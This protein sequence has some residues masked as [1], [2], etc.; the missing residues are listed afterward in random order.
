MRKTKQLFIACSLVTAG[1]LS[2]CASRTAYYRQ[3]DSLVSAKQYTGAAE[4]V[5]KSRKK[6][7]GSKNGLLYWLDRGMLLHYAGSY[8][9]SNAAFENAKQ[10]AE[11]QMV[12]SITAEASTF[13]VND[14]MRPYAGEDFERALIHAFSALNYLMLGRDDEALVEARQVDQYLISLENKYGHD[15]KYKE[16]AFVRY[17]MG[18]IYEDR[19]ELNDAYISYYQ[20]LQAYKTYAADYGTPV[21]DGLADDA[22]R[23]A[24]KLGMND[25]IPGLRKD[26]KASEQKGAPKDWGEAV[27]VCYL[28]TAPHK[29]DTF[30]E[31]SFGKA[32][33][34]VDAVEAS[35]GEEE[36]FERA[37]TIAR[38]IFAEE[39]IRMAFPKYENSAYNA[40]S[41]K[42]E[43]LTVSTE[44]VSSAAGSLVE[45]IGEIA[46]KDLDDRIGRITTKTIVRAAVKFALAHKVSSKVEENSNN[47]LLGWIAKKALT[48]ASAATELSDKRGWRLLPDKIYIARLKAPAGKYNLKL[49]V[50]GNSGATVETLAFGDIEL[51][52]GRKTFLTAKTTK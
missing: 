15:N 27:I 47:E 43:L 29:I 16:D 5:E 7:Y 30:F 13:L 17:L 2:G 37:G 39:Q 24:V 26:W 46:K 42:A 48:M 38:G 28:G 1:I 23:L 19:G 41:V 20:A 34:Y 36:D 21:P 12:K 3:V 35:E 4:L 9:E 14:N 22:L 33:L 49:D 25:D 50:L 52:P 18:L 8:E 10:T 44:T 45:N 31:I 11:E 40:D 51:K 32:W 6:E